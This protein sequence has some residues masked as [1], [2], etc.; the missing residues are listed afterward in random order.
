MSQQSPWVKPLTALPASLRPLVALQK[1]H[2]GQLLNPTR[3]WGRSPF[4]F[5]LVGL[6]VGH[7]ERR[8]SP[9]APLTR[10]LVMTRVSQRCH[11]A[12]CIDANS[13]KLAG[14][15]GGQDKLL[16]VAQWQTAGGFSDAEQAA[17]A[18]AEAMTATPPQ[19]DAAL[20]ARLQAHY[21]DQAI[22]ELTAI[23]A[24][25][26]LSARFNSAL[27]IPSQGLCAAKGVDTDVR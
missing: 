22:T 18:Y 19:I 12:F 3:W 27:A 15:Q 10:A 7:L 13:L 17:L 1:K 8:A 16:K 6:F 11:C 20:K 9:V 26:N 5:W 21:N 2:Y 14:H 25:Q 23:I 24:F 4:L